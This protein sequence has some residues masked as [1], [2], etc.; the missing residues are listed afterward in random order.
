MSKVILTVDDSSSIR[1]I[2]VLKE[3][4]HFAEVPWEIRGY[5][6]NNYLEQGYMLMFTLIGIICVLSFYIVYLFLERRGQQL[7][8]N[9]VKQMQDTELAMASNKILQEEINL[10][11]QFL[12]DRAYFFAQITHE[13]KSPLNAILGFN[14]LIKTKIHAE[15]VNKAKIEEYVNKSVQALNR[16]LALINSIL[17]ISKMT[18]S[19]MTYVKENR[20]MVHT[21]ESHLSE[22]N[23]LGVPRNVKV[24]LDVKSNIPYFEYDE[25]R[26]KQ[27]FSNLVSNAV[28][29]SPRDSEVVI[30]LYSDGKKMIIQVIDQGQGIPNGQEE[31]IFL[32]FM[33]STVNEKD[34]KSGTGLGLPLA[35]EIIKAHHGTIVAKNNSH[36]CG[37]VFIIEIDLTIKEKKE[38]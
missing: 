7:E 18:E 5:N 19:C 9:I 14:E 23:M 17:D 22:L 31:K 8:A 25:F 26:W 20:S 15:E 38:G 36:G 11:E 16:Q 13:L 33:Q 28:K 10:K 3:T 32:A 12:K 30:S 24:T 1:A 21:V 27:V 35:R 29:F 6:K 37:A 4:I 34:F 2:E